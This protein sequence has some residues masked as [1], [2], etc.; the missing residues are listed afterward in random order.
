MKNN[1]SIKNGNL[2]NGTDEIR[3]SCAIGMN[4][5]NPILSFQPIA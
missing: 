4:V 1:T 2:D 3:E 5:N